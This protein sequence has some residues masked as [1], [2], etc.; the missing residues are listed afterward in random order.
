[1]SQSL[2]SVLSNQ[3][4]R[5]PGRLAQVNMGRT[6][7]MISIGNPREPQNDIW[8]ETLEKDQIPHYYI[9]SFIDI[10]LIS[11]CK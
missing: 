8:N 10:Y 2:F 7:L 4:I 6:G 3:D 5:C 1:M 11:Y 9:G